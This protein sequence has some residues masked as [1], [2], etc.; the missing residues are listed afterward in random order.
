MYEKFPTKLCLFRKLH[1]IVVRIFIIPYTEK[2]KD[3][4]C[5]FIKFLAKRFGKIIITNSEIPKIPKTFFYPQ[6]TQIS[7]NSSYLKKH[8]FLLKQKVF[9]YLFGVLNFRNRF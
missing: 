7:L 1:F 9:S 2:K 3:N 4:K 8:F 5:I 6:T